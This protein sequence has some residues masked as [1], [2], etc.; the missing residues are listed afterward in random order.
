M[1]RTNFFLYS[2]LLIVFLASGFVGYWFYSTQSLK[3]QILRSINES[4]TLRYSD[5][6]LAGLLEG[7]SLVTFSTPTFEIRT[8]SGTISVT[9]DSLTFNRKLYGN[10]LIVENP[11]SSV[12]WIFK[13]NKFNCQNLRHAVITQ[14]SENTATNVFSILQKGVECHTQ[15]NQVEDVALLFDLDLRVERVT[16]H[17]EKTTKFLIK[18]DESMR[19]IN[20][21]LSMGSK[22]VLDPVYLVNLREV[23][24][25]T[26]EYSCNLNGAISLST[27]RRSM[28]DGKICLVAKNSAAFFSKL[29]ENLNNSK[30]PHGSPEVRKILAI[31]QFFDEPTSNTLDMCVQ[32]DDGNI[33][34]INKKRQKLL[35]ELL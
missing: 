1:N 3:S 33:L 34:L 35:S 10:E 8:S 19:K 2:L 32:E 22:N 31:L 13:N 9:F 5:Y 24:I 30:D 16:D 6:K 20:V 4:A 11:N 7:K 25:V 14:N 17:G 26:P 28:I 23:S 18:V 15:A 21:D 12:T 27:G 29:E